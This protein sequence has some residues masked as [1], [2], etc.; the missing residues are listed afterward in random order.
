MQFSETD[1]ETINEVSL[2]KWAEFQ[3]ISNDQLINNK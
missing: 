2:A 3:N 1:Y